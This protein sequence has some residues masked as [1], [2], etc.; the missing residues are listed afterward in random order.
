MLL[1]TTYTQIMIV[2]TDCRL[3]ETLLPYC[4]IHKLGLPFIVS[5]TYPAPWQLFFQRP[6]LLSSSLGNTAL[7]I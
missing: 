6:N 2:A 4:M 7:N 5:I 1:F 3:I